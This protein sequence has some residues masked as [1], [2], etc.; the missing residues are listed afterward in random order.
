MKT[1][2]QVTELSR[3]RA[4]KIAE[5]NGGILIPVYAVVQTDA[6][7]RVRSITH[8]HLT[9][10]TALDTEGTAPVVEGSHSTHTSH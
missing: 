5:E 8:D 7:G 3:Q 4:L 9:E 1:I 6:T 2:Q 10:L